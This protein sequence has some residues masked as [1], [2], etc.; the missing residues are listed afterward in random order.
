LIINN[1]MLTIINNTMPDA[2][3][4][5][6][7][8]DEPDLALPGRPEQTVFEVAGPSPAT[9]HGINPGQALANQ[10]LALVNVGNHDVLLPHRSDAGTPGHRIN[11]SCLGVPSLVLRP[12]GCVT[13]CHKP[14]AGEWLILHVLADAKGLTGVAFDPDSCA[15]TMNFKGVS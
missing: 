13:L 5:L 1:T 7:A 6:L 8:A 14:L 3:V 2:A 4:I 15:L 9:I 12:G 11:A 10:A